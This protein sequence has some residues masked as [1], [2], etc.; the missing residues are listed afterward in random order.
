MASAP[1]LEHRTASEADR[2][3]AALDRLVRH[4]VGIDD[5]DGRFLVELEGGVI[6]DTKSWRVWDWPQG[7]GLYGLMKHV[8]RAG[9]AAT[10]A[11]IRDWF[12]A[13]AAEPPVHRN[14]NTVSPMLTLA[15][16]AARDRDGAHLATLAD[17]GEWIMRDLPRTPGGGFQHL[18]IDKPNTGQLWDD[19]LFMTVLP[20]AR[21]GQVLGRPRY[22][23]EAK[24]QFLVHADYLLD[25]RTGLWFHGWT[26]EGGHHFSG[27]LWARGNSWIT[28]AIPELVDMLGLVPGNGV[29]DHLVSLLTLQAEALVARQRPDGLWPT[30]LDDSGTYGE[31]SATAGFAYGLLKGVRTGCLPSRFLDA[32]RRAAAAVLDRVGDD[33]ALADVS[34]GTPMFD[35]L[36][37]YAAVPITPMPYGQAM[38]ILALG[39][40]RLIA[41]EAGA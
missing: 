20:L 23:E 5:R 37:E 34:F 17:W 7:V 38:A 1:V 6:A 9:D 2:I 30:L 19:T 41:E 11:L 39:E 36:D 35:T 25:R 15:C 26:F 18:V 27:A 24:R 14:I 4:L 22:V 28:M 40:Y 16:L 29:R 33:G 12:A 10:E 31:A 21:I 13:R 8:E 3:D 32:G